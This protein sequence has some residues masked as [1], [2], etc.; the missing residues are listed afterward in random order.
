MLQRRY[1]VTA[2][3]RSHD[4]AADCTG[5]TTSNTPVPV[6]FSLPTTMFPDGVLRSSKSPCRVASEMKVAV[7]SYDAFKSCEGLVE[8][9]DRLKGLYPPSNVYK[10]NDISR[11]LVSISAISLAM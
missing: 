9:P 3:N 4:W 5:I 8:I 11:M 1:E 2:P 6:K 7:V 10:F